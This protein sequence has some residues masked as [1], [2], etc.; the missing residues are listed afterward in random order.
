MRVEAAD[1]IRQTGNVLCI[2]NLNGEFGVRTI[3]V[4]EMF[5]TLPTARSAMT[6]VA[7]PPC[8]TVRLTV[9]PATSSA[10]SST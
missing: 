4:D 9:V 6:L 7:K 5:V 8:A 1:I 3:C 10:R 2:F